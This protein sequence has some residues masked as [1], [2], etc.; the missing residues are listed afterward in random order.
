M[1]PFHCIYTDKY[2]SAVKFRAYKPPAMKLVKGVENKSFEE[3]LREL[4][5]LEAFSDLNDSMIPC[6]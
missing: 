3:W 1:L 2:S 5:L 6:I 4:E